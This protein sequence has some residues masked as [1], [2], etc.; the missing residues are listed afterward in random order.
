MRHV[1]QIYYY[2]ACLMVGDIFYTSTD[3]KKNVILL[4]PLDQPFS[5]DHQVHSLEPLPSSELTNPHDDVTLPRLIEALQSRHSVRQMMLQVHSRAGARSRSSSI[6]SGGF[7]S[8]ISD[9]K[10]FFAVEFS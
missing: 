7:E 9:A 5:I 8:C 2:C 10:S 4:I 1:G 6:L 3:L